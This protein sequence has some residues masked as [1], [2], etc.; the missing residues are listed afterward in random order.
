MY[1]KNCSRI[2]IKSIHSNKLI[3]WFYLNKIYNLKFYLLIKCWFL[4]V[5]SSQTSLSHTKIF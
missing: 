5:Q 1:N 2:N 4:G 3:E